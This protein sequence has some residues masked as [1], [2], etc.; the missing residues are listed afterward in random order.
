[1][2]AC[3]RIGIVAAYAITSDAAVAD[4]LTDIAGLQSGAGS[5]T[6]RTFVL[7]RDYRS[8]LDNAVL[9]AAG[10]NTAVVTVVNDISCDGT[11]T[12][13]GENRSPS[14][15]GTP[16]G[17]VEV[18]TTYSFTP[19][20]SDPDNNTLSFTESGLPSWANFDTTTGEISGTPQSGDVGVYSNILIT[21]SD[22]Q[23]G[24]TL[25]PFTIDNESVTSYV[26][27]N[28]AP[29]TYEFVATSFTTSGVEG[30]HSAPDTRVVP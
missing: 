25:D 18:D 11:Q 30:R 27:E 12:N 28:L 23:A 17:S 14:I 3:A 19:T 29:G 21:V 6:I 5:S 26:V 10:G 1:M 16:A 15:A 20:S 8:R 2:L 4:L 24:D 9:L 13:K 22:G 7:P